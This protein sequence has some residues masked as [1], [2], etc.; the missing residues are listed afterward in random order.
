MGGVRV[1]GR[2]DYAARADLDDFAGGQNR[3]N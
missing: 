2:I 1:A 3:E